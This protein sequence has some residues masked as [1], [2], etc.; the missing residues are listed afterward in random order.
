MLL[1][2]QHGL[3]NS[4]FSERVQ[5]VNYWN[6]DE[7]NQIIYFQQM[8]IRKLELRINLKED[9]ISQESKTAWVVTSICGGK[10]Q[11]TWYRCQMWY[12]ELEKSPWHLPLHGSC[13]RVSKEG[14]QVLHEISRMTRSRKQQ[15]PSSNEVIPRGIQ[16]FASCPYPLSAPCLHCQLLLFSR[17]Y[18]WSNVFSSI[19][20]YFAEKE[21]RR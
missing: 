2:T 12:V 10:K 15:H 6:L 13:T 4:K 7:S 5:L 20:K 17:F 18:I 21:R 11:K 3:I 19:I 8:W 1:G 9:W 14:S 16:S